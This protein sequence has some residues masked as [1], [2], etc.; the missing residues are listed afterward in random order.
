M[1]VFCIQAIALCQAC[2]QAGRHEIFKMP[3][4][5]LGVFVFALYHLA[6]FG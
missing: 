4:P 1:G 3:A 5:Y 6:L 2:L